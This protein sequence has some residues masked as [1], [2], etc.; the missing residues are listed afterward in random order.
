MYL[1]RQFY[2]S[3][4]SILAIAYLLF[5]VKCITCVTTVQK[6]FQRQDSWLQNRCKRFLSTQSNTHSYGRRGSYQVFVAILAEGTSE[7]SLDVSKV[8]IAEVS[9]ADDNVVT[10]HG[11][12]EA[13][14][15]RVQ[16]KI[17]RNKSS[18]QAFSF[19]SLFQM[20]GTSSLSLSQERSECVPSSSRILKHQSFQLGLLQSLWGLYL[21]CLCFL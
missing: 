12:P 13:S 9:G 16:P 3:N 17:E 6:S 20:K 19:V 11:G 10:R 4:H 8:S 1:Y 18:Q 2:Y 5:I 14:M 21:V 7:N 15:H